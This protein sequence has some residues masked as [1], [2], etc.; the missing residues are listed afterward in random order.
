MQ[1]HI[2]DDDQHPGKHVVLKHVLFVCKQSQALVETTCQGVACVM[3]YGV[4]PKTGYKVFI[5]LLGHTWYCVSFS[6]ALKGATAEAD[7]KSMTKE[8][9]RKG[10]AWLK[11]NAPRGNFDCE[12]LEWVVCE[13]VDEEAPIRKFDRS[14]I[15]K[16]LSTLCHSES[17]VKGQTFY[18]LCWHD[19]SSPI[20]KLLQ[21]IINKLKTSTLLLVG[22]A[23]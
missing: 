21:P 8:E 11:D 23:G 7:K 17:Q 5:L 4:K 10:S 18:P 12:Q 19:I 20:R 13:L 14:L 9:I 2:M 15:D 1:L 16:T 3:N 6:G 22:E